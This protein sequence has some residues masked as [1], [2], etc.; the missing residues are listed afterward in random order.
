MLSGG[1]AKKK[2]V[3]DINQ[4]KAG[5]SC[6]NDV[7]SFEIFHGFLSIKE[8]RLRNFFEFKC[9]LL[10]VWVGGSRVDFR[11][12]SSIALLNN[13]RTPSRGCGASAD[14]AHEQGSR[15]DV[16]PRETT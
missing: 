15:A 16:R 12:N 3:L 7:L 14:Y 2:E 13:Q 10:M 4:S 11:T 6:C 1:F 9:Y 8:S 5:R